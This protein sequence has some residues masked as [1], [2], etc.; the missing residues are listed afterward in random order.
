MKLDIKERLMLSFQLKILEKLYPEANEYYAKHRKAIEEGY[1]LHYSWIT[2]HL[3]EGLKKEECTFVLD[4]LDMYGSFNLFFNELKK[5]ERL[6][7]E[8]VKF[9]GF[10]RNNEI[11]YLAYTN[12]CIEDLDRFNE[13][14]KNTNKDYN[15]LTPVIP[16]YKKMVAKWNEYKVDDKYQLTEEQI[17]EFINIQ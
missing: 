1:E 13:I 3:S 7:S 11:V 14:K 9:P 6:T 16:K 15:S 8:L 2:K 12:Y 5:P 4:V 10:D 17:Y